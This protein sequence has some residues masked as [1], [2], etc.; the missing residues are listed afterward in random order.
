MSTP[1]L[2]LAGITV[3]ALEQAVAG[4]LATRHLEDLGARVVKLERPD[5]GDFARDYDHVVHGLATHFVWLNRGKESLAID[6]NSERGR[7]IARTLIAQADVFLHNTAPGVV[8]RPG[9]D[10]DTLRAADP[11]LVVVNISGY[12]TSGPRK[13]RQPRYR[14]AA[15]GL[16][17]GHV[18]SRCSRHPERPI[19]LRRCGCARSA[20]A[21]TSGESTTPATSCCPESADLLAQA[22]PCLDAALDQ[23]AA[24]P[25]RLD[26]TALARSAGPSSPSPR[27]RPC[28][29]S[30]PTGS[31]P[32]WSAGTGSPARSCPTAGRCIAPP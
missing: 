3:V 10:A 31:P 5:G 22:S 19:R 25:E 27:P 4:P 24:L 9:L 2:P 23:L 18:L 30:W 1:D 7:R 20:L 28:G 26:E 16:A 13:D 17:A 21:P 15:R 8:E 29:R 6:L 32:C 14:A 12:G 11:R